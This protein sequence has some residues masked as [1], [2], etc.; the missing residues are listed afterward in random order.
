MS[1]KK[2]LL[3]LLIMLLLLT[4]CNS[5]IFVDSLILPDNIE[6]TVYGDGGQFNQPISKTG[7][8]SMSIDHDISLSDNFTYY[9]NEGHPIPANSPKSEI[10]QICYQSQREYFTLSIVGEMLYFTSFYNN[11]EMESHWTV[12]LEYESGTKLLQ[13]AI[14][15]GRPLEFLMEQFDSDLIPVGN[16]K[17]LERTIRFTNEGDAPAYMDLKPYELTRPPEV[18]VEPSEEWAEGLTVSI[19]LPVYYNDNWMLHDNNHTILLGYRCSYEAIQSSENVRVTLPPKS[20]GTITVRVFYSEVKAIGTIWFVNVTD[21]ERQ[22]ATNYN[23][24]AFHPTR[25]EITVEND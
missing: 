1:H 22:I 9:D 19:P 7:L 16:E 6:A 13:I 25:H 21:S 10:A 2:Y 12:R 24:S 23:M 20:K 11:L 4:G 15:P 8:K 18:L 5:D 14:Q 3:T 17:A